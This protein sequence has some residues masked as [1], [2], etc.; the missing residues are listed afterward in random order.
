MQKLLFLRI[1]TLDILLE[2]EQICIFQGAVADWPY[3]TCVG[4]FLAA[5]RVPQL[6][7]NKLHRPR[8]PSIRSLLGSLG[9]CP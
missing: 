1:R 8:K 7:F 3:Q 9:L 6:F 5:V 4:H 2:N